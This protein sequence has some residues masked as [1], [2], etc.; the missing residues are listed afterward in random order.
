MR[1]HSVTKKGEMTD[2][3]LVLL[4]REE[5]NTFDEIL[6]RYRKLVCNTIAMI[7]DN[8]ED[9]EDNVDEG[10][11]SLYNAAMT[12]RQDYIASFRTYAMVCVRN[13]ARNILKR[14]FAERHTQSLLTVSID[15]PDIPLI[16][17]LVDKNF[18]PEEMIIEKERVDRLYLWLA[19]RLSSQELE[20]FWLFAVIGDSYRDIAERKN[21]STKSVDNAIQRARR[22]L[23]AELSCRQ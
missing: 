3:E 12:Y 8:R 16:E 15:D 23:R 6:K 11:I 21:I 20:Y 10:I 9:Y 4:M 14:N 5:P 2:E 1:I 22:K 13:C 19:S 17:K 18:N 7:S